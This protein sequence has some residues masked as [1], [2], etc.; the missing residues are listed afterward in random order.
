MVKIRNRISVDPEVFK[1]FSDIAS[2]KGIKI[3]AWIDSMMKE[4]IKDE[5]LLQELKLMKKDKEP[6][7]D[8]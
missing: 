1:E 7:R 6:K 3:S 2:A 5:K 4:F 8:K